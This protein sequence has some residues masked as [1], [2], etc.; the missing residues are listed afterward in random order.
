MCSKPNFALLLGFIV[1]LVESY[2]QNTFHGQASN[3]VSEAERSMV[4]IHKYDRTCATEMDAHC[5]STAIFWYVLFLP[6]F[7]FF[8]LF[9]LMFQ[10]QLCI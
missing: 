4:D 7:F 8:L 3:I 9:R 10:E 6:F 2:R 5:L 1:S